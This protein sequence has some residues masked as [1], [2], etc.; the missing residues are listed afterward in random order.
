MA[1]VG[2]G[3]GAYES[4]LERVAEA[5]LGLEQRL[6]ASGLLT[7]CEADFA[8]LD[9]LGEMQF[10]FRRSGRW[11]PAPAGHRFVRCH[12]VGPPVLACSPSFAGLACSPSVLH[13][14]PT[15]PLQK[16][17]ELVDAYARVIAMIEIEVEMDTDLPAAEVLGELV[18][19][20]GGLGALHVSAAW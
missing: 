5:R 18:G 20:G 14:P 8:L 3:P 7:S 2:G 9:G 13:C 11:R 19:V 15:A 6:Q 4:R 17:I 1:A 10:K 16:R 12:A